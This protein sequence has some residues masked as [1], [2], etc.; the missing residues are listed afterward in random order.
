MVFENFFCSKLS[1]N[2]SEFDR[3]KKKDV[4]LPDSRIWKS[5]QIE[6]NDTTIIKNDPPENWVDQ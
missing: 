4:V 2:H 1:E 5:H 3:R 6:P